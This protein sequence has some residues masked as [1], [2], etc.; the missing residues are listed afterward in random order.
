MQSLLALAW[1]ALVAM[2]ALG[3]GRILG[4]IAGRPAGPWPTTAGIGL[5]ALVCAGG[6]LNLARLALAPSLVALLAV[7]VFAFLA[8]LRRC[9]PAL[10]AG[11]AARLEL[12]LTGAIVL[13]AAGLA[14]A[15]IAAPRVFN[16]HDDLQKYLGHPVRMLA[17]GT[18]AAGP[19][20]A[21]GFET[22]GGQ[23]FLQGLLLV[24]LPVPYAA[25]L[26]GVLAF[27]LLLL[28]AAWAGWR[29]LAFF[30]AAAVGPIL[31][32]TVNAQVV[33]VSALHVAAALM[34]TAVLLVADDW[35][36]GAPPALLLG[37]VYAAVVALKPTFALFPLVHLPLSMLAV[38]RTA[39]GPRAAARW[40]LRVAAFAAMLL[41][42][43]VTLHVP[44]YVGPFAALPPAPRGW[45]DPFHL[46]STTP[47]F[48]GTT[49]AHYTA[50]GATSLLAAGLALSAWRGARARDVG[51]DR[52]AGGVVAAALTGVGVALV[53]VFVTGPQ[54]T[55]HEVGLRYAIPFLLG[56]AVPAIPLAL[57]LAG[58]AAHAAGGV[59][60]ATALAVSASFLPV[61]VQR[62]RQA[63]EHGTVLAYAG[64]PGYTNYTWQALSG[65]LR[66]RI[67]SL[68]A[69]VPPGEPLL[70]WVNVPCH[71]DL[72]RNPIGVVEPTAFGTPWA[73]L[74]EDARYVLWQYRGYATRSPDYLRSVARGPGAH[75]RR[76]AMRIALFTEKLAR[77]TARGE[78]LADD[79]EIRLVRLPAGE[80]A[81]QPVERH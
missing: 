14:A 39:G 3:W 20:S 16:F 47:L 27:T 72:A 8:S 48:Y 73:R 40:A 70:A 65:D 25:A 53:L 19:L 64:A 46:L 45:D 7:G 35:E 37:A 78:I 60:V 13:G 56:A 26:D 29:R 15:T 36:T 77:L 24:V 10:P 12:F 66:V 57:G 58:H 55:G 1:C 30:P 52:R 49:A 11:R 80:R 32:A 51:L 71:L 34:A 6:V 9:H 74:P 67:R 18:L 2:A 54:H 43:W 28:L 41:A 69:M 81:K 4:W 68:Q 79:G 61:A 33:N 76:T 21:L 59:L 50:L 17:T 23:A 5:A 63:V 31:V 62:A 22:L 38:A 44:V 75:E 42:P